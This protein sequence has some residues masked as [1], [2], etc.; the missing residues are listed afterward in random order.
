MPRAHL[1]GIVLMCVAL[2]MFAVN[3]VMGKW[4]VATYPAAQVLWIRS[5]A[6][7]MVL[8][9]LMV[10]EGRERLLFPARPGLHA[11]RVAFGMLDTYL[12]YVAV[13]YLPLVDVMTYYLAAP[14]FVAAL[15]TAVLGERLT[16]ARWA[17]ILVGFIGVLVVLR[18]SA[19]TLTG[20]AMIALAGSLGFSGLIVTTRMLKD[21]SQTQLVVWQMVGPLLLGLLLLPLG[22]VTPTAVDLSLLMLLGV[23]AMAAHVLV[24]RSLIVAPASVVSP[25]QYSLLLWAVVFGWFVFGDWPDRWTFAGSVIIIGAG[26]ALARL[27]AG[28]RR[29]ASSA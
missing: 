12:F 10:R 1:L 22:F 7:L 3:D 15:A 9:P 18:P 19:A 29:A 13:S 5:A 6:A 27:D 25:W 16:P 17:V 28:E 8:V 23:V 14:I 4:L 2:F 24:A 20:P 21:A 11:A 26:L